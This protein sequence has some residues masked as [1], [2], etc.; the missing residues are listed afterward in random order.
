[1]YADVLDNEKALKNGG[2]S[3]KTYQR[4]WLRYLEASDSCR[5]VD[6]YI[7]TL[8]LCAFYDFFICL[9]IVNDN[10]SFFGKYVFFDVFLNTEM[11]PFI[12]LSSRE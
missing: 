8:H 2:W 12:P 11:N 9:D 7:L 4:N 1:M 3:V 5:R 10:R 6:F